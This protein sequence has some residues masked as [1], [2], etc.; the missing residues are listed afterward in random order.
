MH[1]DIDGDENGVKG[2][3]RAVRVDSVIPVHH[4]FIHLH[5]AGMADADSKLQAEGYSTTP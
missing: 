5:Y 4:S 2:T 1:A 3:T